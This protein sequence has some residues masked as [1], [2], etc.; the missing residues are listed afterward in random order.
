LEDNLVQDI[1]SLIQRRL[2]ELAELQ[3]RNVLPFAYNF[4][5]DS[6]SSDIINSFKEG[7]EKNVKAA[8]R[9]VAI[10]RMGKASFAHIR[11]IKGKIQIYLRKDDIGDEYEVFKLLDIGDIIGIEGYVFKTKTGEISIHTKKLTLLSKSIRPIPIVKE[12]TDEK[13]NKIVHDQF[14]DK[15]LRY[16]QRYVDLIVNPEVKEVFIKRSKLITSL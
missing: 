7:V 15:E 2:E 4:E 8:G 14:V 13:G 6:Y 9:I 16:R 10:R 5:V 12:E 1:N 11:D 3:K